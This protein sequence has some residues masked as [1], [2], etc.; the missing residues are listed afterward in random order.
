MNVLSRKF[1]KRQ[2]LTLALIESLGLAGCKNSTSNSSLKESD[3]VAQEPDLVGSHEL[4]TYTGTVSGVS[5]YTTSAGIPFSITQKDGT[6]VQ[7]VT[8]D[9]GQRDWSSVK[10]GNAV[11]VSV[12]SRQTN[13]N[14]QL[15]AVGVIPDSN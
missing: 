3:Q 4:I 7:F 1:L 10:N 12:N 11:V 8:T 13:A 5:Q 6:K 15:V 14:G 2:M 9:E